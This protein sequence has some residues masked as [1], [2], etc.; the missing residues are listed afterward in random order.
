MTE[1]AG[2]EDLF[3][4]RRLLL[5]PD[6]GLSIQLT[7]GA[8]DLNAGLLA[9]EARA[10]LRQLVGVMDADGVQP[11]GQ[12]FANAPYLANRQALL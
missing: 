11:L 1:R 2:Y 5:Q 7:D 3:F 4:R 9:D 12:S 6:T 10:G 8:F